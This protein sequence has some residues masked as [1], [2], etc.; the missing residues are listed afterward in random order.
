MPPGDGVVCR[1]GA[2]PLCSPRLSRSCQET[3]PPHLLSAE[4]H[5][6]GSPEKRIH[7]RGGP[8][9]QAA[10]G[11][12]GHPTALALNG[13][14]LSTHPDSG[15]SPRAQA[16]GSATHGAYGRAGRAEGGMAASCDRSRR[17][18]AELALSHFAERSAILLHGPQPGPLFEASTLQGGS[19]RIAWAT[20]ST[21]ACAVGRGSGFRHN[22]LNSPSN[23]RTHPRTV[24]ACQEN[25]VCL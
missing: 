10:G 21:A 17:W 22:S 5:P 19:V 3:A 23:L 16:S 9:D 25:T 12:D 11:R 24:G 8:R 1:A 20:F 18:H 2:A 6:S 7:R 14:I 13:G 4:R 15:V